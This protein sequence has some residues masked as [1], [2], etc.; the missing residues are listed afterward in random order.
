MAGGVTLGLVM[1]MQSVAAAEFVPQDSNR[2]RTSLETYIY[3]EV[4]VCIGFPINDKRKAYEKYAVTFQNNIEQ[5]VL[6]RTSDPFVQNPHDDRKIYAAPKPNFSRTKAV[7]DIKSIFAGVSTCGHNHGFQNAPPFPREFLSGN[8]SGYCKFSFDYDEDGQAENVEI[9]ECT[10]AILEKP[11]LDAVKLWRRSTGN[12]AIPTDENIR[13]SS[14]I[15]FDLVDE[16]GRRLP[17]PNGY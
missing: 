9:T 6:N 1:A 14:T 16:Y 2:I 11:T 7:I 15:R 5:P 10:D 12:C 4:T 17:L 8:H 3:D 13:Q